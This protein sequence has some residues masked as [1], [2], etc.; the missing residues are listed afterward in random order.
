MTSAMQGNG[1]IVWK[2]A[3]FINEQGEICPGWPRETPNMVANVA[4]GGGW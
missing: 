1:F 4:D 2:D 3:A